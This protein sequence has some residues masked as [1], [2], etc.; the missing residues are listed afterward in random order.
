MIN[1]IMVNI[2]YFDIDKYDMDEVRGMY[3]QI[4]KVLP[5]EDT[6]V[7][8]PKGCNLYLDV[9]IDMLYYYR[10]MFDDLIEERQRS[11]IDKN[12]L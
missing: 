5:P 3:N 9:P 2:F 7:A 4:A 1:T 6:I 10:Q 8:I 12:D 11:N